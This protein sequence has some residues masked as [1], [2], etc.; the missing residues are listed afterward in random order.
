MGKASRTKQDSSR[1]EKIAAQ[2]QAERR[3][4]RR[5]RLMIAGGALVAVIAIVVAI[6]VI[7]ANHNSS[8]S[9]SSANSGAPTGA[10]L[11]SVLSKVT[12]VPSSVT[13]AAGGGGAAVTP[14]K[15]VSGNPPLTSNGHPEV[16]YVGAEYCPYCAAERWAMM[17]ALSKFGTFSGVSAIRS[18]AANGQGNPEPAPNTATFSF[19]GSTYTSNY[20]TFTPKEL[21]TNHPIQGQANYTALDTLSSDQN[22][23]FTKLNPNGYF[24]FVDFGNQYT[25]IGASYDPTIL[26]GMGMTWAQIAATLTQPNSAIGSAIN[27]TANY[28]TAA[29]CKLTN[30]QPA[31][32]CTSTV[33]GLESKI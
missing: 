10:A 23:V 19:H 30:N 9:S 22:S 2:R 28:M 25:I 26:K 15:T 11:A 1:R 27:G 32:A 18:A 13:D 8:A 12:S 16:L 20:I 6:V 5:T 29:I 31:T 14:P 7:N 24:P 33:Q 17:V 21:E 3:A 4:E